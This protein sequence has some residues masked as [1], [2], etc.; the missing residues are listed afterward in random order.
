MKNTAAFTIISIALY[1]V[2]TGAIGQNVYRCGSSYSQKPCPDAVVVEV[3]DSRS[4]AQKAQADEKTRRETAQVRTLEKARA[5]EEAQRSAAQAKLAAAEHKKSA[6]AS[7]KAAQSTQAAEDGT[8]KAK[9]KKSAPKTRH[10]K[11][12]PDVFIAHAPADKAKPA[13]SAGKSK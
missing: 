13:P 11:K 3:D 12:E 1:L 2:S 8:A 6:A 9:G 10:T 7:K 5:K 4:K